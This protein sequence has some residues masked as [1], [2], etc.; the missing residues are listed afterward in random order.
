MSDDSKL[1]INVTAHNTIQVVIEVHNIPRPV[2]TAIMYTTTLQQVCPEML[3]KEGTY[4]YCT[5]TNSVYIHPLSNV[6]GTSLTMYLKW[7]MDCLIT[8]LY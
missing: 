6:L 3:T 2:D 5:S 4:H 8:E 1:H 7:L